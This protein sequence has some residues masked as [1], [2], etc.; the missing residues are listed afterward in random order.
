[1]FL[2][3]GNNVHLKD[4]RPWRDPT[5]IRSLATSKSNIQHLYFFPK[6]FIQKITMVN[7]IYNILAI[8]NAY[9]IIHFQ[10]FMKYDNFYHNCLGM[11][12]MW[13]N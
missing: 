2:L 5:R 8:Y 1:M 10:Y 12:G 4:S 3:D 7:S 11:M 9:N 13:I 6:C